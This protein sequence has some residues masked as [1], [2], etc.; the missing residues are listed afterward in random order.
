MVEKEI[1]LQELCDT[2]V[3][4]GDIET[5]FNACDSFIAANPSSAY[6]FRKRAHLYTRRDD[7]ENAIEDMDEAIRISPDDSSHYFFRG[8]W[9]L[10]KGDFAGAESDQ[11]SALRIES[12]QASNFV[13]ESAYFFRALARLKQGKFDEALS[14]S[15][16]V[17]D[18]F[19]IYLKS[20]GNVTKAEIAKE[21]ARQKTRGDHWAEG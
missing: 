18:D 4:K 13:G 20:I 12:E 3:K 17:N 9:K 8:W 11:S 6:G 7:F 5:A 19:I 15:E 2:S 21:A 14:D 1:E 10:E 16:H